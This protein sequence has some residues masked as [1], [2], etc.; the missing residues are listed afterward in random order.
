VTDLS[1]LADAGPLS[2]VTALAL[3]QRIRRAGE[4]LW[5]LLLEAYERGAHT[6]L[7]YPTWQAYVDAEFDISRSQSYRL[8]NQ[9]RVTR[10]I[11]EATADAPIR[12]SVRD[13]EVL[14]DDIEGA[15]SEVAELVASGNTPVQAVRTAVERRRDPTPA[16]YDDTAM[17][18]EEFDAAWAKAE[19]T[20]VLTARPI[21]V[22]SRLV[23]TRGDVLALVSH[24]EESEARDVAQLLTEREVKMIARWLDEIVSERRGTLKAKPKK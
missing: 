22:E 13:A 24:I 16:R 2:R 10:A 23:L 8:I 15:A 18:N 20:E 17:T 6:V 9:A 1:P 19:P 12:V 3:T 21:P 4:E 5:A 11:Q 14:K 7:G